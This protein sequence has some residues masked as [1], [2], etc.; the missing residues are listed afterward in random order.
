M[1]QPVR[2]KIMGVA[3]KAVNRAAAVVDR[4]RA[5][6][7]RPADAADREYARYTPRFVA[8]FGFQAP[9]NFSTLT[10]AIPCAATLNAHQKAEDGNGRFER[11]WR[12]HFP[13]PRSFDDWHWT[14]RLNQARA[15]SADWWP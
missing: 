13:D 2:P 9:P 10:A 4:H 1:M 8:E 6:R 12:G 5:R 11:G 15:I 7:T 14:T 3:A